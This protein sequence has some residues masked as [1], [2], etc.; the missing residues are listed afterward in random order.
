MGDE[1][2][3]CGVIVEHLICPEWIIRSIQKQ[4]G[5]YDS[6]FREQERYWK[7]QWGE[8]KKRNP[9]QANGLI[10]NKI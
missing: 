7:N 2:G 8:K 3:F 6:Q 9:M 1:I 4:A 5:C 10:L